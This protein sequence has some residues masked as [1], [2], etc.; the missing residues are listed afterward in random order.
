VI[1]RLVASFGVFLENL[2]DFSSAGVFLANLIESFHV[3]ACEK[4]ERD[5]RFSVKQS[6]EKERQKLKGLGAPERPDVQGLPIRLGGTTRDGSLGDFRATLETLKGLRDVRS[7]Q[8][9][10]YG[11]AGVLALFLATAIYGYNLAFSPPA[12][13]GTELPGGMV[14]STGADLADM[15]ETQRL[16]ESCLADAY[17]GSEQLA[18]KIKYGGK[19]F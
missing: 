4:E 11:L 8:A 13:I 2:S 17:G 9:E 19:P 16:R 1:F 15:T 14:R 5:E 10:E 6:K 7:W 12:D 18:C 3:D